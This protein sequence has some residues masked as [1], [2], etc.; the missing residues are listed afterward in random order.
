MRGGRETMT[1]WSGG[2]WWQWC[3]KKGNGHG[4]RS[5]SIERMLGIFLLGALVVEAQCFFLFTLLCRT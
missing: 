3:N 2:I 4:N 1:G 5:L